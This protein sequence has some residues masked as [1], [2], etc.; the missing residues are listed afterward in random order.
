MPKWRIREFGAVSRKSMVG[1]YATDWH[2][3]IPS[4]RT[5]MMILTSFGFFFTLIGT[6]MPRFWHYGSGYSSQTEIDVGIGVANYFYTLTSG[7]KDQD[8]GWKCS[9][10]DSC[11][12]SNSAMESCCHGLKTGFSFY[13]IGMPLILGQLALAIFM[14]DWNPLV[15]LGLAL[16]ALVCNCL[17]LVITLGTCGGEAINKYEEY[18]TALTTALTGRAADQFNTIKLELEGSF[19]LYMLAFGTCCGTVAITLFELYVRDQAARDDLHKEQTGELE[20][21]TQAV[22]V[23][24]ESP[25]RPQVESNPVQEE[26]SAEAGGDTTENP[27]APPPAV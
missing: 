5:A 8:N 23:E 26:P 7:W 2:I 19:V 6:I 4:A 21:I 27:E 15:N 13:T 20:P 22:V 24:E 25:D 3:Y 10:G 9:L 12:N 17:G 14:W 1:T 11:S 16:G 18:Y